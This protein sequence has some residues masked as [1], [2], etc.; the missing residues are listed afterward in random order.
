MNHKVAP[1]LAAGN[2]CIIKPS[3]LT[4][5]TATKLAEIAAE[6]GLPDGV[7][8]V[9]HGFGPNSAGEFIVSHPDVK[10]ISLT[11]G[12]NNRAGNNESCIPALEK[13]IF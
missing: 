6:A 3:E 4:P 9:V 7:L 10:L 13:V 2:T 1:C 12:N 5:I 11:G 8:N